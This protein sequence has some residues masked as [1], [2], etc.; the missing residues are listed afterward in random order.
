[1]RVQL[2]LC[3][4]LISSAV[5]AGGRTREQA[6]ADFDR[7]LAVEVEQEAEARPCNSTA[8]CDALLLSTTKLADC[9]LDEMPGVA[10]DKTAVQAFRSCKERHPGDLDFR[11]HPDKPWFGFRSAAECAAK[12]GGK[13]AS[14]RAGWFI[15]RA[16]RYIYGP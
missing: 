16:C 13:T 7:L 2:A 15:T 1:M 4:A 11:T 14:D 6:I 12:K 3:A 8:E 10:N 9:I 5:C